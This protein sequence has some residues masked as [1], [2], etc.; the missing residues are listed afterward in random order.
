MLGDAP[1]VAFA[2]STDLDR[3]RAFYRE[4]LGLR[5]VHEDEY[6]VMFEAGGRPLRVN[7]VQQVVTAPYTVLGWHVEDVA[8]TVRQL[9]ARGVAFERYEG[10]PQDDVGVWT[11]PDGSQVAWFKDPDGNLLSVSHA[12]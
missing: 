5:L 7:R 10:L 11:A 9:T 3:A 2:A 8:A 12:A 6:G 1:L 4:T